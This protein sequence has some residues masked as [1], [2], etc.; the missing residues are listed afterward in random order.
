MEPA[1][2]IEQSRQ[3]SREIVL[4][5]AW[6]VRRPGEN[7]NI[8]EKLQMNI[9]TDT[10][11]QVCTWIDQNMEAAVDLSLRQIAEKTF[12]SAPTVL[13]VI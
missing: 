6:Q 5:L 9:F 13:R 2:R 10:E 7:M 3:A 12:T 4:N 8:R 11:R 1:W